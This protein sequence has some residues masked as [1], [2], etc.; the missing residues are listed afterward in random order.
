MSETDL[1]AALLTSIGYRLPML[2]AL[3]VALVMLL[4]TPRGK[5]RTAALAA[6]SL[7]LA[8]TMLGGLLTVTPLLLVANGAFSALSGWNHLLG[9]GHVI[10]SLCEAL[11]I[12]LLAWALVRALRG[13]AA[14]A[15]PR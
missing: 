14:G 10:L 5:V 3:G 7:L 2:I 6:L 11:G 1:L 4:D 13:A 8:T 9:L 15:A 12:V